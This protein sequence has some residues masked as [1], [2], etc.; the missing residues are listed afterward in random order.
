MTKIGP[1]RLAPEGGLGFGELSTDL[2]RFLKFSKV[3]LFRNV[4]F[5]MRQSLLE[6]V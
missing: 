3:A 4:R 6:L 2:H 5:W 1:L